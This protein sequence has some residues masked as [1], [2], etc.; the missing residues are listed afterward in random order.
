METN[1]INLIVFDEQINFESSKELLG[2]EGYTIKRFF[3]VNNYIT[4]ENVIKSQLEN[5]EYFFLVVHVFGK[6]DNLKG[7]S[8]FKGSGILDKHPDLDYMFISEGNKKEQIQALMLEN[9]YIDFLS[10]KI[11]KYHEVRDELKADRC[12]AIK[13]KDFLSLNNKIQM[14]SKA[15]VNN[16][17]GTYPQCD[18]AII[19]ALEEDE[20]EKVLPF[21]KTEGKIE[22][23]K[24]LIE[25]GHFKGKES[26]KIVYASQ[27][28]TGM[29]DASILATE[30]ILRFN[31]KYLIMTGVLGGKP[32]NTSIGD[33]VVA[34]KVFTIDKGKIDKLG[35]KN[36]IEGSNT[37]GSKITE[38]KRKKQNIIDF[39]RD[40]DIIYK[41]VIN[42][43]FGSIA[44]VR[45]VINIEGYFDEKISVIDRKS[46]A[47]EMESY[48]VA[49]ACELV[50][51][52]RTI[53][54]IIKSVMDNTQD[55]TD[56]AK[57]YAAWS[58]AMFVKYILENDLI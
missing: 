29:I 44:C 47:L 41:K 51:N 6:T 28:E 43:H 49:R 20:M 32:K 52:G 5:D 57:P 22:N 36:E 31:P 45:Q 37:D 35:F 21:I 3:C 13:I 19:T 38:F 11:C 54:L 42:I 25:Y 23:E 12:K 7:I 8:K 4:F 16:E 50:N 14:D 9:K 15:V 56:G 48:G 26:K 10:K 40:E 27:L 53:P 55:K 34:S 39:I 17:S 2:D 30:L 24:H 1:K 46:I 18:Y 58:S 33:V